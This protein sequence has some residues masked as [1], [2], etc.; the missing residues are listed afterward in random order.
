MLIFK[1]ETLTVKVTHNVISEF[2]RLNDVPFAEVI[3]YPSKDPIGWSRDMLYCS[4]RIYNPTVLGE[5]TRWEVGDLLTED[6]TKVTPFLEELMEDFV[7]TTTGKSL[8][9][10]ALVSNEKK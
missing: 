1:G 2:I 6:P 3:K 5:L 4:L 8:E 7:M 10:V 9:K